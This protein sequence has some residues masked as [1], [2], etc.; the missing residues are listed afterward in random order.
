M[1]LR[2]GCD[3]RNPT[4]VEISADAKSVFLRMKPS[5]F[6]LDRFFEL[7]IEHDNRPKMRLVVGGAGL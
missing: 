7:T 1:D 4:L 5:H 2:S 3:F 6:H